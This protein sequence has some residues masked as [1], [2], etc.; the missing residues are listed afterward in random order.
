MTAEEDDLWS[1]FAQPDESTTALANQGIAPVSWDPFSANPE[2]P[3]AEADKEMEEKP[4]P[5]QP[6][7]DGPQTE[8]QTSESHCELVADLTGHQVPS[9]LQSNTNQHSSTSV[10]SPK[11][12]TSTPSSPQPADGN[13]QYNDD[14]KDPPS[15]IKVSISRPKTNSNIGQML[16]DSAFREIILDE[17]WMAEMDCLESKVRTL[18]FL[19]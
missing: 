18:L 10:F 14:H 5:G 15:S 13:V 17:S 19:E 16:K 9:I 12:E 2:P 7:P 3:K 11:R 8:T 4:L 6:D 1:S